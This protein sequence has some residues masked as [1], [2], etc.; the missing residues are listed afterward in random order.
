MHAYDR[1]RRG[2]ATAIIQN[3]VDADFLIPFLCPQTLTVGFLDA[4]D[5]GLHRGNYEISLCR[6]RHRELV[7]YQC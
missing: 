6:V 2:M 1:F 3:D 4:F 5:V 7:L